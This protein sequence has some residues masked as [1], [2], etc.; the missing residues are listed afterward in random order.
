MRIKLG[1]VR[2]DHQ[3]PEFKKKRKLPKLVS[4]EDRFQRLKLQPSSYAKHLKNEYFV[5]IKTVFGACFA[6]EGP[7]C[8]LPVQLTPVPILHNHGFVPYLGFEPLELEPTDLRVRLNKNYD[9]ATQ[10]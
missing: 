8:K 4:P 9:K 6:I 2:I 5:V 7:T 10:I 3:V 1:E